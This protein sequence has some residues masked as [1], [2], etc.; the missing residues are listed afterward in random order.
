MTLKR[1]D[2]IN[3]SAIAAATGVVSGISS[4]RANE[5]TKEKKSAPDD[6]Q[7]M[8]ADVMPITVKQREARV[9]KAQRLLTENKI[10]ALVLDAGTSLLYFTGIS[11][12]PSERPMD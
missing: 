6:I 12:W 7:S 8:T 1:R 11:W 4:C 3:L 2:F 9:E 10:E 5:Q